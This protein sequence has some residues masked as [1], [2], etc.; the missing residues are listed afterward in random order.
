MQRKKQGSEKKKDKES[1]CPQSSGLSAS[2]TPREEGYGH[3]WESDDQFSS[4]WPD[5]ST[6]SAT[7]WSCTRAH[8]A[9]MAS[10][11]FNLANH[12]THVVLDLGCTRSLGSKAAI[13]RFQVHALYC[14][15]TTEC[16]R[17]NKSF[18]FANS[19]M[20]TCQESCIVHFPDNTSVFNQS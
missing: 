16:C 2:E 18:V 20:E 3:S 15:I 8:T 14:S 12:P 1:A 7:G 19:E 4:Y 13:K 6:T 9:W 11:P 10:V 17:C 5:D